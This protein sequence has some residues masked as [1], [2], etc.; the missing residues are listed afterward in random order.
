MEKPNQILTA[1]GRITVGGLALGLLIYSV[2][3]SFG[4]VFLIFFG[5]GCP[6]S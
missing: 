2:L 6:A 5:W 3:L 4:F 1:I